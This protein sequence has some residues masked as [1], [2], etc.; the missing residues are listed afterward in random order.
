MHVWGRALKEQQK[1]DTLYNTTFGFLGGTIRHMCIHFLCEREERW[2]RE[3]GKEGWRAGGG[4]EGRREGREVIREEGSAI[5][6][7]G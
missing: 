2:R 4:K 3:G 1:W 6:D 7:S 5:R